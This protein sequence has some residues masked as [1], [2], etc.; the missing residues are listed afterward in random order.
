MGGI[1]IRPQ[2]LYPGT[3]YQNGK[4]LVFK[5]QWVP[6]VLQSITFKYCTFCTKSVFMCFILEE[7]YVIGP[8]TEINCV[9]FVVQA[10]SL[11]KIRVIFVFIKV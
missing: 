6:Y 7:D 10:S 11:S 2:S 5:Y 9:P 8:I 1:S 4:Y 3:K